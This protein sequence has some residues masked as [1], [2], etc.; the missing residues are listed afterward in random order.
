MFLHITI[1]VGSFLLLWYSANLIVDGISALAKKITLSSF[2]VSFFVLGI[3]TSIPE[4]SIGINALI[5]HTPT[6]FA[7]NLIGASFVLYLLVIPLLAIFGGGIKLSHEMSQ[8]AIMLSLLVAVAPLFLILDG[9][10]TRIEG[11]FIIALYMV[12]FYSIEK[13][14]NLF[15]KIHDRVFDG[16][17]GKTLYFLKIV[18]GSLLLFV[19]SKFIVDQ[20]HYFTEFFHREVFLVSLLVLSVG[21]NLPELSIA[22]AS[23]VKKN[24]DVAFGDYVGSAAANSL[25][26]GILTV[27]NGSFSLPIQGLS[28][29]FVIFVAGLSLFFVFTRTKKSLSRWEGA[30]LLLIYVLFIVVEVGVR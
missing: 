25:F 10:M 21:T 29:T 28:R 19:A 14:K 1:F 20:T 6:L 23:I 16:Q 26:F 17:K 18:I 30:V 3:L 5:N 15:E 2:A 27:I 22:F 9:K 12:L 7:G 8:K 13:K 24:K 4:L 11:F